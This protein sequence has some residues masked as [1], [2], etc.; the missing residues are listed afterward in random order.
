[1]RGISTRHSPL[2]EDDGRVVRAVDLRR[3]RVEIS[4]GYRSDP[5]TGQGRRDAGSDR[6]GV[7]AFVE[8]RVADAGRDDQESTDDDNRRLGATAEPVERPLLQ[9]SH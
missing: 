3:L 8:G 5:L 9:M 1:M 6:N 2:G 4:P 7:A